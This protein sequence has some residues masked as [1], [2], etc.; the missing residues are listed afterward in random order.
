MLVLP[1]EAVNVLMC[2]S[3]YQVYIDELQD[4]IICN[5]DVLQHLCLCTEKIV[6]FNR[7]TSVIDTVSR[8]HMSSST[9]IHCK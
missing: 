5:L 6:D 9:S 3:T 7:K 8:Q 1:Q 2:Y 4:G